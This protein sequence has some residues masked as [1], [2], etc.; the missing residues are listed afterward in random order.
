MPKYIS[1]NS[2]TEKAALEHMKKI[3]DAALDECL[4]KNATT[5]DSFAAAVE[6][7]SEKETPKI[8]VDVNQNGL[9]LSLKDHP[10]IG[11]TT[12]KFMMRHLGHDESEQ[13]KFTT[14]GIEDA[15]NSNSYAALEAELNIPTDSESQESSRSTDS[16][17]RLEEELGINI[18]E[19][20]DSEEPK[21]NKR[22]RR[23]I[24]IKTP[25]DDEI[26]DD[27]DDDSGNDDNNN[28]DRRIQSAEQL[29][30][31]EET[32]GP[33]TPVT[34][35]QT[36]KK[37]NWYSL[38]DENQTQQDA[39]DSQDEDDNRNELSAAVQ[40]QGAA[41]AQQ[42]NEVDGLTL[43][44]L[45]IQTGALAAH[46]GTE[47]AKELI[48]SI[49]SQSDAKKLNN[50]I[51]RYQRADERAQQLTDRAEQLQQTSDDIDDENLD[52]LESDDENQP[53]TEVVT[54][55]REFTEEELS[56]DND[57][58][59]ITSDREFTEQ[60]ITLDNDSN[61]D[62]SDDTTDNHETSDKI[63]TE[64]PDKNTDDNQTSTPTEQLADAINKT[65]SK[66]EKTG[67]L[68]NDK[69][70]EPTQID[71]NASISE[72]LSQIEESLERLEKRL[73]SLEERIS[74]LEAAQKNQTSSS[75]PDNMPDEETPDEQALDEQIL[76][77]QERQERAKDLALIIG[78]KDS[79][80]QSMTDSQGQNI[81]FESFTDPNTSSMEISGE[82]E[83]G[84]PVFSAEINPE[85]GTLIYQNYL[86]SDDLD[87]MI[88]QAENSPDKLSESQK[89]DD[90]QKAAEEK[91]KE[92][93][94]PKQ[95]R[96][97]Q[98][99]EL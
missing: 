32:L 50:I 59:I 77:E 71:R 88:E 70:S 81:N 67:I 58:P 29:D 26:K 55:D 2:K 13:S 56:P 11:T 80:N 27:S 98:Q 76:D 72:Q 66:L 30:N 40:R 73:D 53:Q 83:E 14:K 43:G 48:E 90:S 16:Q 5:V 3:C 62:D 84:D 9:T 45:T 42:G 38:D 51:K 79:I 64:N 31:N 12:G 49:K 54:S 85:I 6:S 20:E 65:S 17:K 82:T 93:S 60:E 78:L 18:E 28:D 34:E 96:K 24:P 97:S 15:L 91:Q 1:G 99:I 92:T 10:S 87:T 47:K 57:E 4:E 89:S 86:S 74:A 68:E 46:I 8:Q 95:S 25:D 35:S 37:R 44:G 7:L 41:I 94:K 22:G 23:R 61:S 21:K 33:A 36:N 19:P 75:M 52:D 39:D 63:S 69:D